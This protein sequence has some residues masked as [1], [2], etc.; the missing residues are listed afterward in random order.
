MKTKLSFILFFVIII[1]NGQQK[2]TGIITNFSEPIQDVNITNLNS[3]EGAISDASGAFQITARKG[4]SLAI[5]HVSYGAKNIEINDSRILN[6]ELERNLVSEVILYANSTASSSFTKMCKFSIECYDQEE[7]K[8][9]SID[10][11]TTLNPIL[12]PNPSEGFY[13]LQLSNPYDEVK[14]VVRNMAGQQILKKNFEKWQPLSFDISNVSAG[15]Y[16]VNIEADG[17]KLMTQ[18]AV[19]K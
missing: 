11:A 6:I 15:I 8:G 14:V 2:I 10:S 18:R 17:E 16:L 4:D 3:L 1:S 19:K 7:E 5:S 12:F 13:Q 9:N